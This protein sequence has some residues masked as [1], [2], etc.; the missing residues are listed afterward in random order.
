MYR[1]SPLSLASGYLQ[2]Q[3]KGIFQFKPFENLAQA[4]VTN[5][6]I[7]DFNK[8]G[9]PDIL[10][11]VNFYDMEA[12]TIRLDARIGCYLEGDSKGAFRLL[13]TTENGLFV[14][15]DIRNVVE[16]QILGCTV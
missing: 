3:R 8:D 16:K 9:R 10:T 2:N 13:P 12:K 6:I 1:K 5:S 4:S 15:G 14:D 7:R 11:A